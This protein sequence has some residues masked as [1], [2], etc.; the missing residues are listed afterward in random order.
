MHASRISTRLLPLF[1]VLCGCL[2]IPPLESPSQRG[3]KWIELSSRHFRLATDLD[4]P[5]AA[6]I[7]RTF[8][9]GYELLAKAVFGEGTPPDV[10]TNV[11]S[12]RSPADIQW[13]LPD[14]ASAMYLETLPSDLQPSPT[15]VTAGELSHSTRGML[16]HELAHRLDSVALGPMPPRSRVIAATSTCAPPSPQRLRTRR[17]SSGS[18]AFK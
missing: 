2:S 5:E 11:I 7:V 14:T 8:E 4:G 1:I 6:L 12:F 17:C 3:T 9:L 13:F 15:L 10:S 18:D 16:M